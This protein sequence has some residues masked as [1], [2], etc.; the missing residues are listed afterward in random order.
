MAVYTELAPHEIAAVLAAY[1]LPAPDRVVPEPKGYVNTNHHVWTGGRRYFLRVAEASGDA[2]VAFEA[3]VHRFLHAAR[4]PAPR[5][6]STADGAPA[7]RVRGKSALLFAYAPGEELGA[8]EIAP[9]HC[10]RV[11]EALARLHELSAGF[12]GERANPYGW[13]RVAGWI[14]SLRDAPGGAEVRDALPLLE[15][16]LARAGS[17]PG[18][19]RGLVHGDLFVDNVLWMGGRPSAVLDWEMSCVEAFAYDLGVALS[20]WCWEEGAGGGFVRERARALAAGYRGGRRVEAETADALLPFARFAALRFAASRLVALRAPDPGRD[21]A[22]RK[23]WRPYRDR[24]AALG[25]M[26]EERFRELLGGG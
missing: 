24:L 20:A 14:A 22:P 5:L 13:A 25:E 9:E 7:A 3:E 26:G 4:F 1:G 10:R 2:D 21:R 17:L 12:V 15:D 6:L 8:G 11:G 18:A 19:P 16:E 23:D